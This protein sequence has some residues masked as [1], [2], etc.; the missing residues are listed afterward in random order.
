MGRLS[1]TEGTQ[2]RIFSQKIGVVVATDL[3]NLSEKDS[4]KLQK[5]IEGSRNTHIGLLL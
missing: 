4:G 3:N 5:A 1:S 2:K